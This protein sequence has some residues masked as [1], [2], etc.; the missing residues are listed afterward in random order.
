MKRIAII[1]LL[2]LPVLAIC[3]DDKGR[4]EFSKTA[5]KNGWE[6]VDTKPDVLAPTKH[7][8]TALMHFN[9]AILLDMK[10]GPAWFGSAYTYSVKGNA[11]ESL[12]LYRKSLEYQPDYP[13]TH[14]NIGVILLGKGDMDKAL[15]SLLKARDL[16]PERGSIHGNLARWYYVNKIIDKAREELVLAYKYKSKDDAA[17][18][19]V[20][21]KYINPTT[22]N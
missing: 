6:Q 22:A 16:A 10:S 5:I 7:L 11:D 4:I 20:L 2:S 19:K 14:M 12:K 13:S 21:S 15:A 18:L 1:L 17:F 3:D 8:D 9:H